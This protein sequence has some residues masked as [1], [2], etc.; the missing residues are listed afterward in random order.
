MR[1]RESSLALS[2]CL[3]VSVSVSVSLSL[4]TPPHRPTVFKVISWMEAGDAGFSVWSSAL[5]TPA[6]FLT[7]LHSDGPRP[8]TPLPSSNYNSLCIARLFWY[9]CSRPFDAICLLGER[10]VYA[11]GAALSD[12]YESLYT[13]LT[14]ATVS[15]RVYT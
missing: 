10:V 1:E 11:W 6:P 8:V 4:C 12:P 9:A 13:G 3:S 2:V 15:S 14:T 5:S 7:R